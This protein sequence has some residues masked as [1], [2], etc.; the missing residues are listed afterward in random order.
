MLD[1]PFLAI[2]HTDNTTIASEHLVQ[3]LSGL[4]KSAQAAFFD[5]PYSPN[6]LEKGMS[7]ER[8]AANIFET[9][10]IETSE[11]SG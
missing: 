8:L 6:K 10:A 1:M 7:N 3:S 9:N 2:P 11:S 4:S 5:L